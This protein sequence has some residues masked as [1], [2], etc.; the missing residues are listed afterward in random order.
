MGPCFSASSFSNAQVEKTTGCTVVYLL[1]REECQGT[2]VSYLALGSIYHSAPLSLGDLLSRE[3]PLN[4]KTTDI[5]S[6]ISKQNIRQRE[7]ERERVRVHAC[8]YSRGG[9]GCSVE[10]TCGR[11]ELLCATLSPPGT[12]CWFAKCSVVNA[13]GRC[14]SIG[15]SVVI[16]SIG[17][18]MARDL[19]KANWPS[20]ASGERLAQN[21]N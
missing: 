8:M 5:F 13:S 4:I 19:S 7:R 3:A 18:T 9:H 15:R 20:G 6:H 2:T 1:L 16:N 11:P 14:G 10:M 12:C 17:A 21:Q